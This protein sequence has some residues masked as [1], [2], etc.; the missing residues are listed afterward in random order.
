MTYTRRAFTRMM[1]AASACAFLFTREVVLEESPSSGWPGESI[2]RRI[3][4]WNVT[5]EAVEAI[6]NGG[7]RT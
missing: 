4:P 2:T 6:R 7:Y 5:P 3:G 1:F